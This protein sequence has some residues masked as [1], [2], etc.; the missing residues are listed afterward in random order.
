MM[1][2]IVS[3]AALCFIPLLVLVACFVLL[4]PGYSIWKGALA[5]ALGMFTVAPIAALQFALGQ[6]H[7][8][9]PTSL[10]TL[11][12]SAILLNGLVEEGVKTALLFLMP[13]SAKS[14]KLFLLYAITAGFALGCLESLIYLISG[15]QHLGLRL[16]TAVLIHAF[17]A[18]LDGLFVYSVKNSAFHPL[19]LFF[20][21]LLH[22]AYN[23]L[24]GFGEN[25]MYFYISFAVVL[26]A[27]IECRV[28][29]QRTE[30]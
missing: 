10:Q 29:Y 12:V 20:S 18:G 17:C 30:D 2:A 25:T 14:K 19:P 24:A 1:G 5:C 15:V 6:S 22:G 21:V 16:V 28:R 3:S 26:F 7:L 9:D 13:N 11:L 27:I 4:V 23:Y 8:L